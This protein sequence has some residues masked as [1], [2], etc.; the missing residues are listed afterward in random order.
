MLDHISCI[1]CIHPTHLKHDITPN[2]IFRSW[3]SSHPPPPLV[4]S[5]ILFIYILNPV[6]LYP[7]V[8]CSMFSEVCS[9]IHSMFHG[10]FRENGKLEVKCANSCSPKLYYRLYCASVVLIWCAFTVFHNLRT[11]LKYIVHKEK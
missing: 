1:L 11:F 6:T 4:L 5:C 3:I 7:H 2:T 8:Q 10:P 9:S